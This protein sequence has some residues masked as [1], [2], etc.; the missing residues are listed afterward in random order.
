MSGA[1]FL[2]DTNV[3]IGFLQ[4]DERVVGSFRRQLAGQALAVSC[5]TRM[6]LLS[7]PG[8]TADEEALILSFISQLNVMGLSSG[9]EDRAIALRRQFRF[10]LPDALIIASAIETGSTLVTGDTEILAKPIENCPFFN[11][12][13]H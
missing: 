2:L 9:I 5:I 12:F 13:T 3:V 6:E 11:P 8:I 1:K 7:F 10:K 4:G